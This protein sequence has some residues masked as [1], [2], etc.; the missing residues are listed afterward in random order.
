MEPEEY[1]KRILVAVSGLSP[2]ILT[3]T[4]YALAVDQKPAFVPTEIHL[5]STIEGKQRAEN[6]L[7]KGEVAAFKSLCKEYDLKGITFT[8]DHIHVI[9]NKQGQ[10]LNDIRNPDD[11]ECAA[12]FIVSKLKDLTSDEHS[13]VHVSI[14]GGRKT[15]G[16]Y[17]GYALSL[18]GRPQDRL[19]HVLV[20]EDF[21]TCSTFYYPT[22]QAMIGY[23]RKDK[24]VDFADAKV[25]LAEIPFVR[26]RS[27][28]PKKA[29][30]N[31]R[32][33][34][35]HTSFSH[36][37]K[38]AELSKKE[39][40]LVIDASRKMLV[41]NGQEC[42]WK[43]TEIFLAFYVW[44][45]KQTVF[46]SEK[47]ECPKE[48]NKGYA[49]SFL[50]VYEP[51]GVAKREISKTEDAFTKGM[52]ATFFNDKVS[53]VNTELREMMGDSLASSFEIKRSGKRGF[54]LYSV[55][56]DEDEV[57]ILS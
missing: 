24:P 49:D 19:S 40:S 21:E 16:Y 26:L 38:L 27:Y 57:T 42:E 31:N 47:L 25:N 52:D 1:S 29:V 44:V 11:N 14:A 20:D 50:E 5:I 3:E 56:L 22:K 8:A 18:F 4:L 12:D 13:A 36:T 15:M 45:I 30:E 43:Q 55:T 9:E 34:S 48:Y 51:I 23:N 2:A 37:V 53:R 32:L 54:S 41:V 46:N 17:V 7:L 39:R 28:L 33:I 35:C 10:P 6:A